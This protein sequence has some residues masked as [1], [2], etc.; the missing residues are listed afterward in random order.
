MIL[1]IQKKLKISLRKT[2]NNICSKDLKLA[3]ENVSVAEN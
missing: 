3:F 2:Y 1:L